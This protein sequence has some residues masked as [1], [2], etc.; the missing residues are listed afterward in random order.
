MELSLF[1]K[2]F[3]K[4]LQIARAYAMRA[5]RSHC[6]N[7]PQ[8]FTRKSRSMLPPP[9]DGQNHRSTTASWVV[10]QP[11]IVLGSSEKA[12]YLAFSSDHCRVTGKPEVI[13]AFRKPS[14]SDRRY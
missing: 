12:A 8:S 6:W 11:S 5:Q 3:V 1:R 9:Q 4:F 13:P 14:Q 10:V 7:R 2:L